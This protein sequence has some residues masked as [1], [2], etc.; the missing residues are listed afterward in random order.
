MLAN[1]P[2]RS[3]GRN[4]RNYMITIIRISF[5][6]YTHTHTNTARNCA[7]NHRKGSYEKIERIK[8]RNRICWGYL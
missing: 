4:N 3:S 1:G 6:S 5:R 8:L 7:G 2:G